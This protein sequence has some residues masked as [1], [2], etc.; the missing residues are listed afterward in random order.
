MNRDEMTDIWNTAIGVVTEICYIAEKFPD[1]EQPGFAK[2]MKKMAFSMANSMAEGASKR[3]LTDIVH[4]ISGSQRAAL[5][6]ARQLHQAGSMKHLETN[7]RLLGELDGI[8]ET[9][10][11]LSSG[12]RVKDAV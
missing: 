8:S 10:H 12:W 11:K 7:E 6:L 2:G 3:N 9:L 4:C 5:E 1:S